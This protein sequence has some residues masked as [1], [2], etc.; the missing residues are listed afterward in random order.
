MYIHT[1]MYH[2]TNHLIALESPMSDLHVHVHCTY[3]HIVYLKE[4]LIPHH[5]TPLGIKLYMQVVNN[6]I[7]EISC[8][9]NTVSVSE[10][11]N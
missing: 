4:F 6:P 2:V 9:G 11:V 3:V 10:Y 5:S 1:C 7:S 8:H